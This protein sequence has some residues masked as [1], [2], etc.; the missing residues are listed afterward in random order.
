MSIT[1]IWT[2]VVQCCS[3]LY[4][5]VGQKLWPFLPNIVK[6]AYLHAAAFLLF[7]RQLG[8]RKAIELYRTRGAS[9]P[10]YHSRFVEPLLKVFCS[11]FDVSSVIPKKR[12]TLDIFVF[13][14]DFL[15]LRGNTGVVRAQVVIW[16][17]WHAK[18]QNYVA[19]FLHT[20]SDS[21]FIMKDAGLDLK[22][23][24]CFEI[25]SRV[26]DEHGDFAKL[27]QINPMHANLPF[28]YE[29]GLLDLLRQWPSFE[30]FVASNGQLTGSI[31]CFGFVAF[32]AGYRN[33]QM[34][35][36]NQDGKYV[37]DAGMPDSIFDTFVLN[38]GNELTRTNES[39]PIGGIVLFRVTRCHHYAIK[40]AQDYFIS[41]AGDKGPLLI[42]T[43][44]DTLSMYDMNQYI[45]IQVW[46]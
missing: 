13:C 24:R 27:I 16:R 30:D 36:V 45:S 23:V 38:L 34:S 46:K 33:I 31:D 28:P 22:H 2:S 37:L 5:T 6:L 35:K 21:K 44:R 15:H 8:L 29:S 11:K 12:R 7:R 14:Q 1:T 40:I 26:I 10:L 39:I 41:K 17:Y 42:T 4:K 20:E 9:L 32:V 18:N 3:K 25:T 19:C 43:L